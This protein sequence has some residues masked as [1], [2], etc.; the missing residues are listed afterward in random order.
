MQIVSDAVR[1]LLDSH[2]KVTLAVYID[3]ERLNVGVGAGSYAG[4]CAGDDEFSFGNACAAGASVSLAGSRP[5]L[6][7]RRIQITWAV[8]S[9]EYPLIT[10]QV[11]KAK[12]AVGRT[13]I[14]VWD[15]MYFAGSEAFAITSA[16]A[17][18]CTAEAAFSAVADAMGVSADPAALALLSDITIPDGLSGL[19]SDVA[20][21]AVAGYI[22]GLVGGNA[23]MSRTGLLTI[24]QYAAVDWETEPYAGGASA[25]NEDFAITGI[26]L[27]REKTVSTLNDDGSATERTSTE[28]YTAGDGSLMIANPLSSQAAADSAFAV[29]SAVTVRPGDYSF[30]G[31]LLLE[32]GDIFTVRSMDGDYAV[33]VGSIS[34][35]FD[36]GVRSSVACGGASEGA[37]GTKGAINQALSALL[38]DYA[39]FKKLVA[40]NA[41]INSA[42]ILDLIAGDIIADRIKAGTIRPRAISG[43][44]DGAGINL[45]SG[46]VY[47]RKHADG[48]EDYTRIV[49][50]AVQNYHYNEDDSF[51]SSSMESGCVTVDK[52]DSDGN[53]ISMVQMNAPSSGGAY[54]DLIDKE[55]YARLMLR[56]GDGRATVNGLTTPVDDDD[57][58]SKAYVDASAETVKSYTQTA[59]SNPN[60]L[61]NWYFGNPVNQRGKTRYTANDYCLDRWWFAQWQSTGQSVDV[62]NG[63]ISVCCTCESNVNNSTMIR[64]TLEHPEQLSNMTVTLSA[65]LRDVAVLGKPRLVIYYETGS[66]SAGR[67]TADITDANANSIVSVTKKLPSDITKLYVTIGNDANSAGKGAFLIE[68]ESMKLEL[69]SVSTLAND[70]PPKFSEQL[71]E[72]QRYYM[73]YASDGGQWLMGASNSTVLY[74]PL[75]LPVPMRAHPGLKYANINIYPYV[76]GGKVEITKLELAGASGTQDFILYAYHASGE[77]AAKSPGCIRFTSGGYIELSAEI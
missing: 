51:L 69:G 56:V 50:H 49:S 33:A 37:A 8:G 43:A 38:A 22:A 4:A 68:V 39:K 57:A 13:E 11:E 48:C 46:E 15:D 25:E 14:E 9:T 20:N 35:S 17:G 7:G 24:R 34:M 31:G 67:A 23:L 21:S 63:R 29:L 71:L 66:G 2:A 72:C 3:G 27:Q 65:K 70:A 73:R 44:V 60:L 41:E 47:V 55:N 59:F 10:G 40:D 5:D 76:S 30:P 58:A 19:G 18:T 61:D 64:Q 16:V 42:N 1:Q 54:L 75:H 45:D 52:C 28:E 36:G 32:P 53:W 62:L 74:A 26:T 12:V 6:K 77:V